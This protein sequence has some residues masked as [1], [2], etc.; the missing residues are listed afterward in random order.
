MVSMASSLSG[1]SRLSPPAAHRGLAVLGE[2]GLGNADVIHLHSLMSSSRFR[3]ERWRPGWRTAFGRNHPIAFCMHAVAP[4]VSD[5]TS[6]GSSCPSSPAQES[7]FDG[8]GNESAHSGPDPWRC[9]SRQGPM[10]TGATR[11]SSGAVTQPRSG[12]CWF[13]AVTFN[14]R[15]PNITD[16]DQ[17]HPGHEGIKSEAVT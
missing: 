7:S 2:P 9:N 8:G 16:S 6:F 14:F 17:S 10:E 5:E 1:T 15:L 12:I 13:H 4:Q 11:T 3:T